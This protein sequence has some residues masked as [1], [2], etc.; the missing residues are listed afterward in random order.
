MKH[1]SKYAPYQQFL[2]R[3]P[4][5]PM[6]FVEDKDDTCNSDVFREALYIA[7]PELF[8]GN[9]SSDA[10]KQDKY[11]QSVMKYFHRACTRATPFGL[12]AG[13][14]V[15]TLGDITQIELDVPQNYRRCTRLDM[16]YLCALIQM[17]ESDQAINSQLRFYPNDSLYEIGGKYRYIEYHY[18][19]T[20]R[21]HQVQSVEIDEYLTLVL[22]AAKNGATIN[23]LAEK[24]IDDEITHEQAASYLYEIID[25]QILK[26]ELDPCVVGDDVLSSLIGKLSQLSDIPFLVPLC[27]I[28]ELL[29]QID[30]Q[31]LGTTISLYAEII[32]LVE[33][34][35]VS[36]EAKFLFQTD[37]YKPVKISQISNDTAKGIDELISFLSKISAPGLNPTLNDFQQAFQA[38][39]EDQEIPL[40]R[41]M[42]G[43]L[44]LG[45]PISTEASNDLSGLVDD[46]VIPGRISNV[47]QVNFTGV[48][49]VLLKKYS[50]C[51]Q[52][53][54]DEVILSDED[55]K[56]A[57]YKNEL[58]DTVAVMIS[59]LSKNR[60][61]IKSIGGVS[62]ANLLGRFG[63][64][65]K[66]IRN[67]IE[68]IARTEAE[69]HPDAIVAEFSH[70]PESRIGNIVSRPI[71]RDHTLHYLSNYEKD[72]PDISVSDLMLSVKNGRL[73][74]R[75]EIHNKEV[76]PRLTCAHN[77]SMSPIPI[78]R[79]LCDLQSQQLTSG[80]FCSWN[81]LFHTLD[82]LP[83]I[84]YKDFILSRQRWNLKPN[85]V[86]GFD[87]LPDTELLSKVNDLM[88]KRQLVRYVLIP[89]ADNELFIDLSDPKSLRLLLS[90][91]SQRRGVTLEEFLFDTENIVVKQGEVG[92]TNEA[93]LI[94][95]K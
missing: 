69:C 62:G 31:P 63:H 17:I 30:L 16:Q 39:Y 85:E 43:E 8:A 42:D 56:D 61:F 72:M 26:S 71:F 86:V 23:E 5:F 54:D 53:H 29:K 91:I 21:I 41:V 60:I 34:I 57:D 90:I 27:R 44:G 18:Q 3:T 51:M 52:Q 64:L 48:D 4:L 55:F 20:Q 58:P 13:C 84:R 40:T 75:S 70:L 89:D 12:F 82:Y 11:K 24:L 28:Q 33:E 47:T 19:K 93:I 78:Y 65:D 6:A 76:I 59:L 77:Y 66:D 81:S 73:L 95:H 50:K 14:S 79:F 38:R 92:F 7:S 88:V 2:L 46:L 94:F 68:Q 37:M 36:Y 25:S 83:R 10:K 32:R 67:L 1:K 9:I 22:N 35:G 49:F 87:K 74:L 45:Y 15:G 80:L